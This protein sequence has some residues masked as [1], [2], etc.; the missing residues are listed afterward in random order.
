MR[1]HDR[2]MAVGVDQVAGLHGHT[3]HLDRTAGLNHVDVRMGNQYFLGKQIKS[4]LFDLS[5]VTHAA[6]G[7]RADAAERTVHSRLHVAPERADRLGVEILN[8]RDL[9]QIKALILPVIRAHYLAMLRLCRKTGRD[10]AGAGIANHGLV[11][12]TD[13]QPQAGVGI[14]GGF[15]A[16]AETLDGVADGRGVKFTQRFNLRRRQQFHIAAMPP[17]QIAGGTLN[18]PDRVRRASRAYP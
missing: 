7:D 11:L 6:R 18:T 9:R 4:Y 10:D 16:H 8:D 12:H 5:H 1:D 14:A 2:A 13:P 17:L 3:A 15:G